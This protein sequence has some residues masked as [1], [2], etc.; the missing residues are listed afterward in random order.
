M[1]AFLFLNVIVTFDPSVYKSSYHK[2]I[3]AWGHDNPLGLVLILFGQGV[4]KFSNF[5]T[6]LGFHI[7]LLDTTPMCLK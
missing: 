4:S 1:V 5:P 6:T 7:P 2:E 3:W